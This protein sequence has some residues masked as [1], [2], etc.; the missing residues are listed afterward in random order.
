MQEGLL[1]PEGSVVQAGFKNPRSEDL[2]TL[3]FFP[4]PYH[5][6]LSVFVCL[7]L[8]CGNSLYL[9][10]QSRL[11]AI[12]LLLLTLF[13]TFQWSPLPSRQN[14]C[15]LASQIVVS[16]RWL[17]PMNSSPPI[18][19]SQLNGLLS[20]HT[21]LLFV[22]CMPLSV[23]PCLESLQLLANVYLSFKMQEYFFT[24]SVFISG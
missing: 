13:Q 20:A 19:D 1:G 12:S 14:S 16:I 15:S 4:N 9:C 6:P 10:S 11:S 2:W 23:F 3:S 22:V 24:F 5:F 17:L 21:V 8:R 7:H 18:L